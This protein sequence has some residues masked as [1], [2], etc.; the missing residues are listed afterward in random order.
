MIKNLSLL[1]EITN[2]NTDGDAIEEFL[3]NNKFFQKNIP[4]KN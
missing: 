2:I 1:E 4:S 3:R